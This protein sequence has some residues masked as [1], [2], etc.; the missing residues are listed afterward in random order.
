LAE[1]NKELVLLVHP[2]NLRTFTMKTIF[3]PGIL[4]LFSQIAHAQEEI[5]FQRGKGAPFAPVPGFVP[6]SLLV[7]TS[8]GIYYSATGQP[9]FR[10]S[11][12]KEYTVPAMKD[13]N[14]RYYWYDVLP[15]GRII[16]RDA[17]GK[18][19]CLAER[20]RIKPVVIGKKPEF[21]S[22]AP[23]DIHFFQFVSETTGLLYQY[24][25]MSIYQ[26]SNQ[27]RDWQYVSTLAPFIKPYRGY[28]RHFHFLS[29]QVGFAVVQVHEQGDYDDAGA[30]PFRESR[31]YTTTDG[32]RTWSQVHMPAN[33]TSEQILGTPYY[34]KVGG[35]LYLICYGDNQLYTSQ[36]GGASFSARTVPNME[37]T[38]NK[39]DMHG[40]QMA[41]D[42][43][44][45]QPFKLIFFNF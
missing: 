43:K 10:R 5:V 13:F 45:Y 8:H 31:L 35:K 29:P 37:R 28:I 6:G 32:A 18:H 2:A 30:N 1:G 15:S 11:E 27:G 42:D 19:L 38:G 17:T 33:F 23:Y 20:G 3:F 44:T 4:L 34:T 7:S 24:N 26:T 25:N 14:D 36:D 39:F 16:T 40:K 21:A 41:V 12:R 22:P 9:P